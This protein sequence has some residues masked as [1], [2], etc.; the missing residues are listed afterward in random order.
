MADD[1]L[2]ELDQI[3][4]VVDVVE[5]EE[6]IPQKKRS[7]AYP[8]KAKALKEALQQDAPKEVKKAGRPATGIKRSVFSAS[9]D[10]ELIEEINKLAEETGLSKTVIAEKALNLF[11]TE[12]AEFYRE[13]LGKK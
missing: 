7:K 6:V 2:N 4:D 5:T 13:M 10:N 1:L 3:Q 8:D 9:L 12:Q 11:M